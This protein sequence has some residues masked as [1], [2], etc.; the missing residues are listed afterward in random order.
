MATTAASTAAA[1]CN[2]YCYDPWQMAQAAFLVVFAQTTLIHVYQVSRAKTLSIVPLIVGGLRG[3]F[4]SRT[5]RIE[6]VSLLLTRP[7][8]F[9]PPPSQWSS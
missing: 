6:Q 3:C 1:Q 7:S 2:Y 9:F 5:H 8:S 4:L